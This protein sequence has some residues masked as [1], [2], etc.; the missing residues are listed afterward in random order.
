MSRENK[1]TPAFPGANG[2]SD[3]T[4]PLQWP[5]LT[6]REYFALMIV[7]GAVAADKH[8]LSLDTRGT[9][10]CAVTLADRLIDELERSK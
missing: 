3:I 1:D 7:Q 2:C 6:K 10:V 9:I 5:G 4:E 8:R